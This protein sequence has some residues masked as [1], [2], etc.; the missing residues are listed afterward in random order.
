MPMWFL[1]RKKQESKP[2]E[3]AKAPEIG[4]EHFKKYIYILLS[5]LVV[6][7]QTMPLSW[8]QALMSIIAGVFFGA[9]IGA[10]ISQLL[11][12]EPSIILVQVNET[13]AIRIDVK[14]LKELG[15][16]VP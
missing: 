4:Y 1:R 16:A 9:G 2:E 11:P 12:K 15:G 13:H 8:W 14:N 7:Y 6:A 5:R 3:E 10:I